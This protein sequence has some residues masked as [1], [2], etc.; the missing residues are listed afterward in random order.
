MAKVKQTKIYLREIYPVC[1]KKIFGIF[2]VKKVCFEKKLR[3]ELEIM[4]NDNFDQIE[5][6]YLNGKRIWEQKQDLL[7]KVEGIIKEAD[8]KYQRLFP[9]KFYS[10]SERGYWLKVL[11]DI[12]QLLK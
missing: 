1:D 7:K 5:A 6:I 12:K 2:K 8:K 10:W 3:T 9:K 4:S 11:E